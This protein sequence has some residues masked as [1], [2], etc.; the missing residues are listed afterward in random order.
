M[1][2]VATA[3]R[4]WGKANWTDRWGKQLTYLSSGQLRET[5]PELSTRE[6]RDEDQTRPELKSRTDISKEID[7]ASK[8][9]DCKLFDPVYAAGLAVVS[10]NLGGIRRVIVDRAGDASSIELSS[11][12]TVQRAEAP[13]VRAYLILLLYPV[14]GFL[15]PWGIVR[16]LTWVGSGFVAQTRSVVEVFW[17]AASLQLLQGLSQGLPFKIAISGE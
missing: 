9:D 8:S 12:E 6:P 15:L 1:Q 11:G 16:V 2:R 4:T 5:S 17:W 14:L 7:A 13:R 3:V 10:V